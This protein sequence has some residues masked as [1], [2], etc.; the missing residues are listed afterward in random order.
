MS[1][2]FLY[3]YPVSEYFHHEI[4]RLAPHYENESFIA[5]EL[6]DYKNA[7]SVDDQ[8]IIKKIA[9]VKTYS[10]AEEQYFNTLNTCI[11]KRYRMQDYSIKFVT[12]SDTPVDYHVNVIGD[13]TIIHADISFSDMVERSIYANAQYIINQLRNSNEISH[14]RIGGFHMRDC[15]EKVAKSAY[16]SGIDVLVDEDLTEFLTMNIK[17]GSFDESQFPGYNLNEALGG[18]IFLLRPKFPWLYNYYSD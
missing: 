10:L 5:K 11:D 6:S 9:L 8:N 1:N 15:V 7:D 16:E 17:R 3:L 18:G 13:D 4:K 12:F 2:T 14:L